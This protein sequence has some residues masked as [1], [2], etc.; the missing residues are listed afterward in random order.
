MYVSWAQRFSGPTEAT[1]LPVYSSYDINKLNI[2]FV[3]TKTVQSK[4]S[5]YICIATFVKR[6]D[7]ILRNYKL[8]HLPFTLPWKAEEV[9][10]VLV[11]KGR[12]KMIYEAENCQ[13]VEREGTIEILDLEVACWKKTRANILQLVSNLFWVVKRGFVEHCKNVPL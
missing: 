6:A 7:L 10:S 3:F 11:L 2:F 12:T 5:D 13:I 8:Q 9:S 1:E 4:S